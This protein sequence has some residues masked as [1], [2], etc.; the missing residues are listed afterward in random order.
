VYWI[1][2]DDWAGKKLL[3]NRGSAPPPQPRP[4][5]LAQRHSVGTVM[6]RQSIVS[7]AKAKG[8]VKETKPSTR[9]E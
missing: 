3:E 8:R 1:F 5:L 4:T 7:H 9:R 6:G 2:I